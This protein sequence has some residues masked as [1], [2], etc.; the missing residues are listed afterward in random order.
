[1]SAEIFPLAATTLSGFEEILADELRSFGARDVQIGR[2]AVTFQGDL[3]FIYKV[4]FRSRLALRVLKPIK[5]FVAINEVA[6]YARIRSFAWEK[7]IKPENTMAIRV[8]LNSQTFRHSHFMAQ[9]AKDAIVDR[10]REKTGDRPNVDTDKPD[11]PIHIYIEREL[12][13]ISMDSSGDSLHMRGYRQITGQAPLNEVLAAGIVELSEWDPTTPFYD[14]MC[15]SGTLAIE[16]AIKGLKM[17]PGLFRKQGYAFEK[18]PDFDKALFDTI[19]E[20]SLDRMSDLKLQIYASDDSSNVVAKAKKNIYNAELEDE[21]EVSHLN[22]FD[23]KPKGKRGTVVLN[24]PYGERMDKEN[25]DELYQKLG[26]AF[27]Q[28]WQ[29][30]TCFIF[31][32]NLGAL[33]KVGLRSPSKKELFNGSIECRLAR[34]D[35]YEGSKKHRTD[36]PS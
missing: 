6:Y 3:G 26:D 2:R 33:K 30:H 20:S 9:K 12:V 22:F 5:S 14:G 8:A 35:V 31:S 7:I 19:V 16:A 11:V 13:T 36:D 4:N 18:W 25:I 34:F 15:G 28:N 17:P 10:I 32:G 1:M 21:I 27:K 29:G 24:P 23:L